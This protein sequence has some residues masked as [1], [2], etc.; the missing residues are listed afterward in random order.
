MSTKLT[1][2]EQEKL[3]IINGTFVGQYTNSQAAKILGLSTRQIKRLKKKVRL[4][5]ATVVIHQLKGKQSNHHIEEDIKE[6]ARIAAI[7]VLLRSYVI[8]FN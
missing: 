4:E 3:A 1:Q 5:G 8:D 6:K 7:A 2:R